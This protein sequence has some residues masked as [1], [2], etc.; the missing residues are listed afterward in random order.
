[1]TWAEFWATVLPPVAAALIAVISAA[2][3]T[4]VAY[5][6]SMRDKFNESKDREALHSAVT[7]GVRSELEMDPHAPDKQVAAAAARYVLEKGAPD[8]VKAF[9][10]TGRD[11]SRMAVSKVTEERAKIGSGM[12]PC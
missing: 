5:L 7:T 3:W 8:A 4:V 9:D 2:A 6:K 12:K 1:M 11:L 10:M